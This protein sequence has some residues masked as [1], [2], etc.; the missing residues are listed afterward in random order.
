V[1]N[2]LA[3]IFVLVL[4]ASTLPETLSGNTPAL[5]LFK[6]GAFLFFIIAYGLPVLIIRE[7][8]VRQRIGFAGLFLIGLGYG[9][10]NEA[11]LAKTVFRNAGVPVDVYTASNGHGQLSSCLGM[12]WRQ[13]FCRFPLPNRRFRLPQASLGLAL[14]LRGHLQ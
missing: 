5:E 4:L 11:L 7:Y 14:K 1:T 8:A 2:R 9:I 12:R 3:P 13:R 10:I 6:P